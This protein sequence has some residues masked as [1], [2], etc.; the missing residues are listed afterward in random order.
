MGWIFLNASE[1]FEALRNEWDTANAL[2]GNH[3]LLDSRFVAPLIR[4][5]GPKRLLLAVNSDSAAKSFALL[6]KTRVGAWST[7]QPAQCPLG[8]VLF[9]AQE[10]CSEQLQE[11]ISAI[12][13]YPLLL[14][15]FHQDPFYSSFVDARKRAN[16][17]FLDYIQTP[18]L[19]ISG[20]F[21]DYWGN[22][23][24]KFKA[25]IERRL[26]RIQEKSVKLELVCERDA[27]RVAAA[28]REYGRLETAGWKGKNGTAVGED[29]LQ[30]RFYREILED[31]CRTGEA[32]IFQLR[33]DDKV[34]AT[35]LCLSR[36]G[37]L[38]SLKMTYDEEVS[39]LGPGILMRYEM[40]KQLYAHGQVG[41]VEFYGRFCDF[42]KPWTNETRTMFHVNVYR[43]RYL[44]RA[45]QACKRLLPV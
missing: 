9:G 45:Q 27:G 31:F 33:L 20:N 4:Y 44:M 22:R 18:R 34:V 38:V 32:V 7:F 17:Q 6:V 12:P 35:N 43:N 29:N 5:F 19:H 41:V 16:I 24:T 42:H 21:E 25:D 13:G 37:M 26:R 23:T 1:S 40:I 36:N 11:L 15:I 14:T 8:L 3:V 28:V 2:C 30:G 39:K 10:H